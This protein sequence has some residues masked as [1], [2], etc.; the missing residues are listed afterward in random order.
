MTRETPS[1]P[2]VKFK[3]QVQIVDLHK[4]HQPKFITSLQ[5]VSTKIEWLVL[6]PVAPLSGMVTP[7]CALGE[8][9]SSFG[10][11]CSDRVVLDY[12]QQHFFISF[13]LE[14]NLK[15]QQQN[16]QVSDF[17]SFLS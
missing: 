13:S 6:G 1:I 14:Q 17:S 5:T 2:A 7:W 15:F 8:R 4:W 10:W 9:E 12:F 11:D 3:H 16:F